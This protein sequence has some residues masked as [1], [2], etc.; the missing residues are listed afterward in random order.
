MLLKYDYD[1]KKKKAKKRRQ[2][3]SRIVHEKNK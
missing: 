2:M 1:E 3:D